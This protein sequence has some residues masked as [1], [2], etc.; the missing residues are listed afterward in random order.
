M[1]RQDL[2]GNIAKKD[3]NKTDVPTPSHCIQNEENFS[4]EILFT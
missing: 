1:T 4:A 2:R 3:S